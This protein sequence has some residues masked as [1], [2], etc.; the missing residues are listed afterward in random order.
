MKAARTELQIAAAR[1][2][3]ARSRCPV[4]GKGKRVAAATSA[5]PSDPSFPKA[6]P[7]P[8]KTLSAMASSPT[9]WSSPANPAKRFRD[10]RAVLEQ[11]LQ[12]EPGIETGQVHLIA[13]AHWRRMRLCC[14]EN[15][16]E[17]PPASRAA[18]QEADTGET[19]ITHRA[20]FR[21]LSDESRALELLNPLREPLRRKYRNALACFK[22][23]RAD[24][25]PQRA[26]KRKGNGSDPFCASPEKR[27]VCERARRPG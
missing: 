7:A 22:N 6:K 8:R 20:P 24:R 4:T 16:S 5:N 25:K 11:E 15:R 10:L 18:R 12:S 14:V 17:E 21:T 23:H 1:A 27:K 2:N 19:P 9:P 3:G 26:Q 13:V